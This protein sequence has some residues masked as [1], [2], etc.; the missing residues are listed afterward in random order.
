VT[1]TTAAAALASLRQPLPDQ[2]RAPFTSN[3]TV[4]E[5]ILLAEVGFEPQELVTGT[6]VYHLGL[7]ERSWR[8]S[9]EVTQ[10]TDALYHA[11]AAAV[12][13]LL[14]AT[15]VASGQGVAGVRLDVS[16]MD[17]T[18]ARFIAVGTALSQ[19]DSVRSSDQ[20]F[21]CNLSGRDLYLLYRTGYR[22]LSLVMGC[23]VYHVGRRS[24][25]TWASSIRGNAEQVLYTRALY[26]ARELA[27]TRLQDEARSYGAEGVVGMEV[28]QA[29]HVWGGRMIEF[30]ALGTAVHRTRTEEP[31]PSRIVCDL[32]E[33]TVASSPTALMSTHSRPDA[34][35]PEV[36]HNPRPIRSDRKLRL[37]WRV[38][39][40]AAWVIF[41][42]LV[43]AF[44]GEGPPGQLPPWV[45]DIIG[46]T[47]F[48]AF[49]SPILFAFGRREAP[50][51]SLA[52]ALLGLVPGVYE[53]GL[54]GRHP[55]PEVTS[56]AVMAAL[57]LG[58]Y[59]GMSDPSPHR[60]DD[61]VPDNVHHRS[62]RERW[63]RWRHAFRT[64]SR[65]RARESTEWF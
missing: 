30:L 24:S 45:Q 34:S 26:E 59:A 1:T 55:I 21:T 40:A 19:H 28:L 16:F 46:V 49:L 44:S 51:A 41:W 36:E 42:I 58:S 35:R 29:S 60:L 50:S 8:D 2:H 43:I 12:S 9:G 31:P 14:D 56:F 10:L 64:R 5:A 61:V 11:R 20:P 38:S 33:L 37:G 3:L 7:V 47:A 6:A 15:R 63:S 27:M 13:R 22:P 52:T 65:Q 53:L 48:G 62:W 32:A 18:L 54:P 17:S 4:D 57:S 39:M 23:C 25:S